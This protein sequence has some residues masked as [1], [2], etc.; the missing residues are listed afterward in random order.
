MPLQQ[1]KFFQYDVREAS[2]LFKTQILDCFEYTNSN[3]LKYTQ[4]MK[5]LVQKYASWDIHRI[6]ARVKKNNKKTAQPQNTA[7]FG[8]LSGLQAKFLSSDQ[9]SRVSGSGSRRRDRERAEKKECE[10]K[11]SVNF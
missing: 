11:M 7:R 4:H 10:S 8:L 2:K 5:C 1:Y 9:A 3:T 6:S